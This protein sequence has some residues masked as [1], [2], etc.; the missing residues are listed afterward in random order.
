MIAIPPALAKDTPWP[1]TSAGHSL[2]FA[3]AR[4][5]NTLTGPAPAEYGQRAE[6]HGGIS[7]PA[8]RL[9]GENGP[10]GLAIRFK[11]PA[12]VMGLA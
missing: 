7:L 6:G 5:S 9:H 10:R 1:E 3:E 8:A 4:N 11:K 12:T 2:S